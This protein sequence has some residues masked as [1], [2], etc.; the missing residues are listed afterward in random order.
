MGGK[1][2]KAF[3][4]AMLDDYPLWIPRGNLIHQHNV[5]IARKSR[6]NSSE[7]LMLLSLNDFLLG[8]QPKSLLTNSGNFPICSRDSFSRILPPDSSIAPGSSVD[9]Q[10]GP[11]HLLIQKRLHSRSRCLKITLKS[12]STASGASFIYILS[13]QKWSIWRFLDNLKFVLPDMS[14]YFTVFENGPKC[15]I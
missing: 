10:P 6:E 7:K 5:D 11:Y 4:L 9:D 1:S 8:P 14:T 15:C 12:H 13:E 2:I 3:F